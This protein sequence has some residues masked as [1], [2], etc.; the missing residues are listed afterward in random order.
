[1][2]DV[3]MFRSDLDFVIEDLPVVCVWNSITFRATSS[4]SSSGRQVEIDGIDYDVDRQI[5]FAR[6]TALDAM[7]P[8][9]RL[10]AGGVPYRVLSISRHPDGIAAEVSLKAVTR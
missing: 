8:D 2:L 4:Q 9:E 6:T 7:K 1:M 3:S 10:T 5:V